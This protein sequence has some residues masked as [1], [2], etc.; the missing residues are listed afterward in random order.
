MR[1]WIGFGVRKSTDLRILVFCS[2][3]PNGVLAA[4]SAQTRQMATGLNV[5][6]ARTITNNSS[7]KL[8]N[9]NIF[10]PTSGYRHD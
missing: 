7:I 8:K 2:Y 1:A 6:Y 9:G 5:E 10:C 3:C 4:V